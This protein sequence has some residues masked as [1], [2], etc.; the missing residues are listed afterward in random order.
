MLLFGFIFSSSGEMKN[1]KDLELNVTSSELLY[2][3]NVRSFY[4]ALDLNDQK[5]MDVYKLKQIGSNALISPSI[6]YQRKSKLAFIHFPSLNADFI[7]IEGVDE[8]FSVTPEMNSQ[9]H[10]HLAMLLFNAL[11]KDKK[12][13]IMQSSSLISPTT[14]DLIGLKV[15]L[16]DYFKLIRYN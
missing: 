2:F 6:V 3:K 16:N 9:D 1:A 13:H 7:L 15:I 10:L 11:E 14:E 12:I 8:P 4:Y 5:R